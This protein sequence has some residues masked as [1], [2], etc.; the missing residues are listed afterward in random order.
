MGFIRAVKI[1]QKTVQNNGK[2]RL[3]ESLTPALS[4]QKAIVAPKEKPMPQVP[5]DVNVVGIR[6]NDDRPGELLLEI[7]L[8]MS[9]CEPRSVNVPTDSFLDFDRF[10]GFLERLPRTFDKVPVS[11]GRLY[12]A[13]NECLRR[14]WESEMPRAKQ[15]IQGSHG[16]SHA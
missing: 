12:T 2:Q 11:G 14:S 3:R 10:T 15:L 7:T 9:G 5:V 13:D 4:I 6:R 16:E 1:G 8:T